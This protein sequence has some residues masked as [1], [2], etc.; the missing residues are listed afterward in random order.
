LL[1]Q[2]LFALLF[3]SLTTLAQAGTFNWEISNLN[4]A[5]GNDEINAIVRKAI[6]DSETTPSL[7]KPWYLDITVAGGSFNDREAKAGL[8]YI[9]KAKHAGKDGVTE[10][11]AKFNYGTYTKAQFASIL[12]DYIKATPGYVTSHPDCI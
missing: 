6:A 12:Y 11:C 4:T 1:R 2:S 8:I 10:K 5:Y 3:G 9:R 7:N